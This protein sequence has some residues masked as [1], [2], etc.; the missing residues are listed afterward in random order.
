MPL[1]FPCHDNRAYCG[2]EFC[3][4]SLESCGC[5]IA[6]LG[7]GARSIR[8]RFEN[9]AWL[10]HKTPAGVQVGVRLPREIV[11]VSEVLDWM[12]I[13]LILPINCSW[14]HR[15]STGIQRYRRGGAVFLPTLQNLFCYL[16]VNL[17]LIY[18]ICWRSLTK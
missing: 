2:K 10:G 9:L 14:F 11:H 4:S 6:D 5:M 13:G 1:P 18:L 15:S 16:E 8:S 17:S 7:T 12:N 3:S